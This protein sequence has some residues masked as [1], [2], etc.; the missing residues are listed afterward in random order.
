MAARVLGLIQ[1]ALRVEDARELTRDR[2]E[3]VL[4]AEA[5]QGFVVAS[6]LALGGREVAGQ[7]LDPRR[8]Q[9]RRCPHDRRPELAQLGL[10]IQVETA[11]FLEVTAHGHERG[12]S[13]GH[14]AMSA[15]IAF[16]LRGDLFT[17]QYRFVNG[18][19]TV[20]CGD[21]ILR[22]RPPDLAGVVRESGML[23]GLFRGSG[24]E[25]V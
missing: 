22:S 24:S 7:T 25:A 1:A 3:K 16:R 14:E 4:L 2:R 20:E 6:E 13:R 12:E 15:S 8:G 21:R 10:R 17:A 23:D 19:G 9:R 18:C 11:S 5:R